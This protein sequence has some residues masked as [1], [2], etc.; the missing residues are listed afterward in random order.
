[1]TS[2]LSLLAL[3]AGLIAILVAVAVAVR[4]KAGFD[5][6]WRMPLHLVG[7]SLAAVVIKA[8][9]HPLLGVPGDGATLNSTGWWHGP[10]AV[11]LAIVWAFLR[12]GPGGRP[13]DT[14]KRGAVVSDGQAAL[15]QTERLKARHGEQLLT[16]AGVW[17][18]PVDE[19]KHFKLIPIA[20]TRSADPG[21]HAAE[22]LAQ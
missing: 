12:Y 22:A 7:M 14:H 5:T 9:M 6:Y 1:M 11:V 17:V 2:A 13:G 16:L 8:L 15:E 4:R 18:P 10:I 20:R 21:T 19:T 3:Y